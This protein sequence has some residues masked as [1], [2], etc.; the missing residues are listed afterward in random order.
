MNKR[1]LAVLLTAVCVT[2]TGCGN[3]TEPN[4]TIRESPANYVKEP[5]TAGTTEVPD[6]ITE[7]EEDMEIEQP[8]EKAEMDVNSDQASEGNMEPEESTEVGEAEGIIMLVVES[9]GTY[10]DNLRFTV[11]SVNPETG[12]QQQIS[13]FNFEKI[14]ASER[15]ILVFPLAARYANLRDLFSPDYSLLA[16]TKVSLSNLEESHAGW[17][18]QNGMF[19]DVTEALGLQSQGDFADPAKYE[20]VG[21]DNDAFV[22][23]S[24]E[25]G[26]VRAS[27]RPREHAYYQIPLE[28]IS[29]ENIQAIDESDRYIRQGTIEV[30]RDGLPTEW[31]D[32]AIYLSDGRDGYSHSQ[33]VNLNTRE[34]EDYIPGSSRSNWSAVLSPDGGTIAFLSAPTAGTDPAA[35]YTIPAEGGEPEKVVGDLPTSHTSNG[36]VVT[37]L[38]GGDTVSFLIGWR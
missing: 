34:R 18:D 28:A 27:Y 8:E 32:D 14:Y 30:A 13:Q 2:M 24:I 9:Y 22:Y 19:Y 25:D 11:T 38:S 31:V 3:S 12:A 37:Q 6:E 33:K 1:I 16:A 5:T 36:Q 7:P 20:A 10:Q 4:T 15:D 26:Y 35:I 29:A 21:F 17:V 23:A